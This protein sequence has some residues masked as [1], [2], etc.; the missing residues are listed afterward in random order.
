MQIK[1]RT[2]IK[3]FTIFFVLIILAQS[4]KSQQNCEIKGKV[5]DNSGEPIPFANIV[6]KDSEN[7]TYSD[8]DG[9]YVI[10]NLKSNS[11][12]IFSCIGYKSDTIKHN[13]IDLIDGVL[14]VELKKKN[15][16]FQTIEF[17]ASKKMNK[18]SFGLFKDGINYSLKI[19]EGI[20]IAYFI[21]NIMQTEGIITKIK[22][23]CHKVKNDPIVRIRLFK[24]S[25]KDESPGEEILFNNTPFKLKRKRIKI[26]VRS[27]NLIFPSDG[28]FVALEI[29][30]GGDYKENK[31]LHYPFFQMSDKT[32]KYNTW[33]SFMGSNWQK[34]KLE[35]YTKNQPVNATFG[36]DV[37]N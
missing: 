29:V 18:R 23:K 32:N 14:T 5:I 25:E 27:E 19:K 7:G 4:L 26:D 20:I 35:I 15:I 31:S 1:S 10:R 30:K 17:S 9:L 34:M 12:I 28:V 21:E 33:R 6:V 8:K 13:E 11:E 36:I 24:K 16:E 22:L 3:K 2:I 37:L